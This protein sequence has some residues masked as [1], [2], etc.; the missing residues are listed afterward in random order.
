MK[1]LL[2]LGLLALSVAL[3]AQ[4]NSDADEFRYNRRLIKSIHTPIPKDGFVPDKETAVAIAYAV[5]VP[6][7]GKDHID[8]ELPLRA[9]LKDGVWMV[10]GTLHCES[11]EGGTLVLEIEKASGRILHMTHTM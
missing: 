11:C 8:G 6:V 5:A 1:A 3:T 2:I 7:Y 4:S 10:L 9:E